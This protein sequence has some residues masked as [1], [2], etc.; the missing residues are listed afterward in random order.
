MSCIF[1]K[2]GKVRKGINEYVLALVTLGLYVQYKKLEFNMKTTL[3]FAAAF[4]QTKNEYDL[5]TKTLHCIHRK[6]EFLT[7]FR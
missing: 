1:R 5:I 2:V 4:A 3:L 7:R 6:I